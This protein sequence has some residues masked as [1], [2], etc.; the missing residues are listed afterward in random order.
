MKIGAYGE[1]MLRL[2]PPEYRLLEQTH[3]LRMDYTGTGVNILGNL[4]HFGLD[5][6]LLTN[7]PDNRL[8]DAAIVNLRKFGLKTDFVGKYHNHIGSYFAEVGFG[9]RPTYVTYQNRHNSSFGISTVTNYLIKEFLETVDLIHICGISLSLTDATWE[10]ACA[11]AQQAKQLG[12]KVCFDFNFRP[13]LNTEAGKKALMKA[14][15]EAILPYCDL[16]FG[17]SRDLLELLE[18]PKEANEDNVRYIQRFLA[19]Y[20]VEWFA[21]TQRT[22]MSEKPY[23]SG[24]IITKNAHY[25]TEPKLLTV[26]DRIGAG[27]AYAAGILLGYAEKW[28]LEKT[29]EFAT[30]NAV[31]AHTLSGDVPLTTRAQIQQIMDY[32]GLDLIR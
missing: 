27:D 11:L 2:T 22:T 7:V 21:G 24:R 28:S 5:T 30:T 25:E 12:K 29:A 10:T 23:I 16:V 32:P 17:T 15:Y 1:V 6:W 20:E 19:H 18:I 13:S 14:R 9:S 3:S 8:G 26:L 31:V 4:A